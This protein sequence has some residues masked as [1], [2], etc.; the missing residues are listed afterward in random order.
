MVTDKIEDQIV[1]FAA[2]REV[3]LGVVDRMI[4][5]DGADKIEIARAAYAS[6]FCA[7]R[8]RDLDRKSPNASGGAVDQD[9]LARLNVTLVAKA[10]QSGD[11]CDRNCSR[12]FECHVAGFWRDR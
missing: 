12:L 2:V 11:G 8:F 7:E 3:F 1:T 5:A 10:L 4:G 6:D 9:F